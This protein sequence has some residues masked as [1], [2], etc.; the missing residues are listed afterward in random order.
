MVNHCLNLHE[1]WATQV[2]VAFSLGNLSVHM[3]CWI[4]PVKDWFVIWI[5][6]AY[7]LARIFYYALIIQSS[8]IAKAIQA[9]T[10]NLTQF[11]MLWNIYI[12]LSI[13]LKAR[14]LQLLI[15]ISCCYCCF[16]VFSWNWQDL[17]LTAVGTGLCTYDVL[18]TYWH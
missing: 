16:T 9:N 14:M 13:V 7:Y 2:R 11:R 4:V 15:C 8:K 5:S 3:R 10:P 12:K 1:H 18:L 17:S 6:L